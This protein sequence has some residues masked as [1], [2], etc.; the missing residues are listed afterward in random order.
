MRNRNM[1]AHSSIAHLPSTAASSSHRG[2]KSQHGD[3]ELFADQLD[4]KL[5]P[6]AQAARAALEER[7][8]LASRPFGAIVSL[9]ARSQE[10]PAPVD[11]TPAEPAAPDDSVTP[12]ETAGDA[13]DQGSSGE[14]TVI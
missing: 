3:A 5:T 4:G 9:L 8:D 6:P 11:A 7:P 10:L 2:T 12:S 1:N 13:P 14:P